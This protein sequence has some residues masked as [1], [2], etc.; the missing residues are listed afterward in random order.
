MA[1]E[2]E[3]LLFSTE[4]MNNMIKDSDVMKGTI[5]ISMIKQDKE[6]KIDNLSMPH[7]DKISLPIKSE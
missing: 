3:G 1:K 6:W 4:E 7:F 5:D 2:K